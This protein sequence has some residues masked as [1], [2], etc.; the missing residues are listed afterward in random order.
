MIDDQ[1]VLPSDGNRNEARLAPVLMI[2]G[3][4]SSVGKS[5][6]V[7]G[8]CRALTRQG[9]RVAP[10]KAQNMSLN[11]HV[12]RDGGEIGVAQAIQAEACKIEPSIDMN[13]ILL[14]PEAEKRSQVVV[15]GKVIGAMSAMQYHGIKPQ[16]RGQILESL[17][18]LRQS[19]DVV[20]V[21]GAGSP[22]EINLKEHDLVNMFV[23]RSV[24]A[25]VIIVGDIDR[26]GVF[27]AF[28]GTLE[29]LTPDERKL[30]K[31][32]IVNKFRGD[33]EL[34]RSGLT[35]LEDHTGKAILGVLPHL[36]HLKIGDEDSVALDDKP[37]HLSLETGKLNVAVLRYPRISNYD[38]FNALENEERVHVAYVKDALDIWNADLVILPGSKSVISDLNW[39][40]A[41]DL[42]QVI[43]ERLAAGRPIMGICGGYQMLA[44]S[45]YDPFLS[46]ATSEYADG[47][48]LV[49][50]DVTFHKEK[51]TCRV[52]V[53]VT[54]F[55]VHGASAAPTGASRLNVKGYEIHMGDLTP[56]GAD[57]GTSLL[58]IVRRGSQPVNVSEGYIRGDGLIRGTLVH[59]LFH[60]SRYRASLLTW[61]Q[62]R[63]GHE[64]RSQCVA[65]GKI[66][67]P[68]DRL[69]DA[70]VKHIDMN[71]IGELLDKH[72]ADTK[73]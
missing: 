59:G 24:G 5:L 73:S 14:K 46:E 68:Y 17:T 38:E 42:D 20:I 66:E 1:S 64:E 28:V 12:T 61:L 27:A 56:I 16:L 47:L 48:D 19:Y 13:P 67:D 41:N 4:S 62:S 21:E 32:F 55:E 35:F 3:T 37:K 23:A 49:P 15:N 40:R 51:V 26:G 57:T 6:L 65:T 39:L 60:D 29:L 70:V 8:I 7:T 53:L 44:R 34:L 30:V 36:D 69:A 31:G 2:Q 45:I 63:A 52:D 43:A 18:R 11:S 9:L 25:P 72:R 71:K 54:A 33:I 10:F 22:A 58:R 50:F